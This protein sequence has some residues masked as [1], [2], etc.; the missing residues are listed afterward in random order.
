MCLN[1]E[2]NVL[3]IAPLTDRHG[4]GIVSI[5]VLNAINKN[6][7][8]TIINTHHSAKK[9]ISKIPYGIFIIFKTL[10][11][12]I[13]F[14]I[15]K[16]K[17]IVYF[18]PSRSLI[19]SNRDFFL[20]LILRILN[21][22]KPQ[23]NVKVI[24]H[25][26]GSD[27]SN[28]LKSSGYG[29]ILNYFY[30]SCNTKM[31]VLSRKH[32]KFALG[33]DYNNYLIIRNPIIFPEKVTAK[34]KPFL[35]KNKVLKLCFISNPIKEKGL[36]ET[37]DWCDKTFIKFPWELNV[38]GWTENDFKRIYGY[39][40]NKN[41][42][43][44]GFLEGKDKFD[45]LQNSDIFLL[46]SMYE[47]QPLVVIEALVFKCFIILSNIEML[48]EFGKFNNVRFFND[49]NLNED[50]IVNNLNNSKSIKNSSN[51]AKKFFDICRF[52]K[53]IKNIF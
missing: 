8:I 5:S 21:F 30:N 37:I 43:F 10:I 39:V 31:I 13:Y 44:K 34:S 47:A 33:K 24:A 52:E 2:K 16:N 7:T 17:F 46:N 42:I 23:N 49:P 48:K 6:S 14:S 9:R 26:H 18:T 41:I 1:K 36:K 19:G 32:K 27:L 12:L 50:I 22:Y 40:N 20:L 4:Q 25:L 38:I 15:L 35:K 29:K 28:L 53:K 3:F 45:I 51:F 11:T